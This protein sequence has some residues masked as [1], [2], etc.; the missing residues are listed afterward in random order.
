MIRGGLAILIHVALGARSTDVAILDSSMGYRKLPLGL[1]AMLPPKSS[2][3]QMPIPG[4][5]KPV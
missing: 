1:A 3:Y 2:L 5:P 4:L